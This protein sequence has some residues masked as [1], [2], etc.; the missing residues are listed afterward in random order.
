MKIRRAMKVSKMFLMVVLSFHVVRAALPCVSM[1]DSLKYGPQ[2]WPE[3][4]R[5]LLAGFLAPRAPSVATEVEMKEYE[6]E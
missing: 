1:V 5:R 2:D 3:G 6:R 4:K